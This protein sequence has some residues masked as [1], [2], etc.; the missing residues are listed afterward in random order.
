MF[1]PVY[2]CLFVCSFVTR[3]TPKNCRWIFVKCKNR[4]TVDMRGVGQILDVIVY[5]ISAGVR[6]NC[7]SLARTYCRW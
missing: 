4:Q 6:A 2:V 3:I 5:R 1:S 7:T